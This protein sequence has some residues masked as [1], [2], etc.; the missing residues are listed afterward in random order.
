MR[1]TDW[2]GDRLPEL[3][4]IACQASGPNADDGEHVRRAYLVAGIIEGVERSRFKLVMERVAWG[5]LPESNDPRALWS[6][7]NV[8]RKR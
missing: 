5:T 7:Y 4:D 2:H 3:G 8:P 1:F 6:F